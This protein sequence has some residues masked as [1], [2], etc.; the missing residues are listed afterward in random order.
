MPKLIEGGIKRTLALASGIIKA[1]PQLVEKLP[2]L[3]V[4]VIR[5]LNDGFM[6]IDEIGKNIVTGIWNGIAK[7]GDWL[8]D[9]VSSFFS[10]IVNGV[11]KLLGIASP[12]KVFAGIGGFMAEG[13]GEGFDSQFK[14]IKKNIEKSMNFED[15]NASINVSSNL[16][17]QVGSVAVPTQNTQN[18]ND[19]SIHLTVVSP[20]GKELARF[21][22]PYMGAQLQLVRG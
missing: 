5:G 16:Q 11:K 22:A 15:A 13:L 20:D 4:S 12:S 9:Q 2:Q 17:K 21:I 14:S 3:V 8:W 1:I 18:N 10:G 19:R 7:M 6:R